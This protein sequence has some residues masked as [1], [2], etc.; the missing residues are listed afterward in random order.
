MIADDVAAVAAWHELLGLVDG[1]VGEAVDAEIVE[2][3]PRVGA[4]DEDVDHVMRLVEQDTA[5]APG[6]LLVAP[7]A[8][9]RGDD[10]IDVGAD[11]RI[12]QHLDR[13]ARGL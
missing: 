10:G 6:A 7:V 11:L 9:F 1:E 13:I 3:L 4:F 5:G 12:A 8:E 2:Q